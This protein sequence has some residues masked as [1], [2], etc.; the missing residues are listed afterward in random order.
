MPYF[1]SIFVPLG[2]LE[3]QRL[4]ILACA[5]RS[6]GSRHMPPLRCEQ[7]ADLSKEIGR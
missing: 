1:Y 7:A 5:V 2:I 4:L 6:S 3:S